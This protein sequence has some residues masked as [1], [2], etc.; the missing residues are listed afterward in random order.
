MVYLHSDPFLVEFYLLVP[1]VSSHFYVVP[2]E[3]PLTDL[4]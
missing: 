4:L 1:N 3:G 2:D